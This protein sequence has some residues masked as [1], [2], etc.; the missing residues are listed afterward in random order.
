MAR[1]FKTREQPM[2]GV[3]LSLS[4]RLVSLFAGKRPEPSYPV[5]PQVRD[6]GESSVRGLYLVGE[7]GGIPLIKLDLN[8]GVEVVERLHRELGPAPDDDPDLLDL[9]IVGAGSSGLAAAMRAHAH[10]ELPVRELS[11]GHVQVGLTDDAGEHRRRDAVVGKQDRIDADL[12]LSLAAAEHVDR[13]HAEHPLQRRLDPIGGKILQVADVEVGV[14]GA[15]DEPC[16]L[17][18]SVQNVLCNPRGV[19]YRPSKR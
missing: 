19:V 6:T 7:I 15:E 10:I 9:L 12:H 17:S 18:S 3:P 1:L 14:G 8:Q 5:L 11:S 16:D 2:R 13:G 4:G